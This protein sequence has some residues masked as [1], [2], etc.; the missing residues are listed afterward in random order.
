MV[1][2]TEPPFLFLHV[3][4]TGGSS[5]EETLY[6]YTTWGFHTITHGIA[7]Q[8]KHWMNTELFD[9]LYKF[10]FVRNPW[11]LQVSCYEYYVKQNNIDMTFDEY[12][13]WKFTGNILDMESRLPKEDPNVNTEWLRSCFY[14]H[15]TPQNYFLIDEEGNY[16]VNYIASF[17]KLQEHY[18]VIC[19]KIGI[20][21][22]PLSHLNYSHHRDRD[23]P[24]QKY[25]NEKTRKI[26]ENRYSLDIKTFGYTFDVPFANSNLMG[27]TN[28]QNNSIQKRGFKTPPNFY[29]TFGD[30]PYGLGQ[31]ASLNSHKIDD[32]ILR[33]K[34]EF[35]RN[36]YLR[37]LS[38]LE[39]NVFTINQNIESLE[40]DIINNHGDFIIFNKNK[41][42]ILGLLD[43][44]LKYQF[45]IGKLGT[46][47]S[48]FESSQDK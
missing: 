24:F 22:T 4:K 33:E 43:K 21:Q 30:L 19:E 48:E 6:S 13:E 45:E 37:R 3:P 16:L 25:Y 10:A 27:E 17:E 46:V 28:E 36:K 12:I 39:R 20:E 9:S 35:Y 29:F 15:R 38:Y 14:I 47:I 8:Y 40:Q 26:I 1:L 31:V 41:E 11:D 32:E 42:E 34:N 7:L 5:V 23:I 18:D 2:S 44:K